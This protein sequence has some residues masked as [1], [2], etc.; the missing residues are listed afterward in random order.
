MITGDCMQPAASTMVLASMR[1]LCSTVRGAMPSVVHV[2]EKT[3]PR[4]ATA[5]RP[6]HSRRSMRTFEY[7]R[8]PLAMAAG[9]N[10]RSVDCLAPFRQPVKHSAEPRQ[11]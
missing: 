2:G 1:A 4:P 10:D 11:E 9:M 6:R 7:T 5:V 3:W 8:A